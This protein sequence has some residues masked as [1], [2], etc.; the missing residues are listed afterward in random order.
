MFE[1]T[2]KYINLFILPNPKFTIPES[3]YDIV[4]RGQ[5]L[6]DPDNSHTSNFT[7]PTKNAA[8]MSPFNELRTRHRNTICCGEIPPSLSDISFF[9]FEGPKH[10]SL[11][12]F[13]SFHSEAS[14]G[15]DI[16]SRNTQPRVRIVTPPSS[17]TSSTRRR[18]NREIA[19]LYCPSQ[20]KHDGTSGTFSKFFQMKS[21]DKGKGKEKRNSAPPILHSPRRTYH[22][23]GHN[24]DRDSNSPQSTSPILSAPAL[25]LISSISSPEN[26]FFDVAHQIPLDRTT[27]KQDPPYTSKSFELDLSPIAEDSRTFSEPFDA[28]QE[29]S[30]ASTSSYGELLDDGVS[31]SLLHSMK[32]FADF[33]P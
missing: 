17:P 7:T 26:H 12:P 18:L 15:L 2:L 24:Y 1:T 9:K 20:P 23:T 10:A 27:S 11:S 30:N 3:H 22:I 25:S 4:Y 19:K 21:V 5:Q 33:F 13:D 28:M 32:Q 6:R 8:N 14:V 31:H 16:D 29:L